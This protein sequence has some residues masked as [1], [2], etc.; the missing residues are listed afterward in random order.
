MNYTCPTLILL[1]GCTTTPGGTTTCPTLP[2]LPSTTDTSCDTTTSTTTTTGL[3]EDELAAFDSWIPGTVTIT[4]FEG[5]PSVLADQLSIVY[6]EERIEEFD[7]SSTTRAQDYNS[8]RSNN[9]SAVFF[10]DDFGDED[11]DDTGT[12][13]DLA[14]LTWD[15]VVECVELPCVSLPHP[16]GATGRLVVK[17]RAA[18]DDGSL[19]LSLAQT[20]PATD[21]LVG[22]LEVGTV[23]RFRGH[24]TVLKASD[25]GG[26]V[27]LTTAYPAAA[28]MLYHQGK[29]VYS[30]APVPFQPLGVVEGNTGASWPKGVRIQDGPVGTEVSFTF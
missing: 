22:T 13:E 21:P 25:D 29:V 2:T 20:T 8:S 11:D 17:P 28:V 1:V 9:A 26:D 7:V 30:G 14:S 5:G 4:P 10:D 15:G 18:L 27:V 19:L 12:D 6:S 24:V 3:T 16:K 23:V